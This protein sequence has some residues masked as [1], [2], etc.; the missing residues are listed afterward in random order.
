MLHPTPSIAELLEHNALFEVRAFVAGEWKASEKT[1]GVENPA[2]GLEIARVTVCGADVAQEAINAAESAFSIWSTMLARKRGQ[3]LRRWA[4]L[5]EENV[6]ELALIITAEQGKPLAESRGEV[7]YGAGFVHWFASEGERAYGETIPSHKPN[8][9]L[10]VSMQ[11]VGV[12]AAIT[13]W[14]FPSAMIARKAAAA[15][16]AGC[17]MIVQPS[18][19]TPLSALALARLAER[20]GIPAGVFQV[21][22]GDPVVLSEEFIS[23]QRVR[24]LS[25]TGSTEV[26]RILLSKAGRT[27]KKVSMELG[28]N[29][30]FIVFGDADLEEAVRLCVEAKFA[31]SGQ[32]CLAANRIYIQSPLYDRF[33]ASFAKAVALLKVGDGLD[34]ESDIGPMTKRSVVEKCRAHV[35]DAL[36][37]GAIIATGK[38]DEREGN[39]VTPTVIV[40]VTDDMLIVR[41]E[42][43]GPVA[44]ILSFETEEEVVARANDCE[45]GLAAYVCTRDL[46]RGIRLSENLQYGMVALN[47]S[48]FTG[49]PIPFGGWKS[50]GLGREG[51]RHGLSEFME[52]KYVCFGNLAA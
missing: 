30:P 22:V 19:D 48:S 23:D 32:D 24:A 31:T 9:K 42:T 8:S 17:T 26:G 44:A 1:I 37:K 38:L 15:L 3:I 6:E 33:C 7:L 12:T 20:A 27:V 47:T 14:N 13:P 52:L 36:S 25:F 39:F 34:P 43:F 50:S 41:E 11:P 40:N 49:A 21:V 10:V 4:D 35:K 18:L 29:A 46:N 2:S 45:M 51:S 28:G 16:A 5:I